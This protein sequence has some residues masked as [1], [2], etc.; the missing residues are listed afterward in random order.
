MNAI[1]QVA[2]TALR[3]RWASLT[4]REQQGLSWATLALA[5]LL[6]WFAALQPAW[7]TWQQ[8]PTQR[9]ALETQALH[10]Q[11][12]ASDA[13]ELKGQSPVSAEQSLQALKAATDRLGAKA[14]LSLLGERAT[15]TVT[16]ITPEQLQAWLSEVRSGARAR[17]VDL[18][19]RR[20]ANGLDG[21]VVLSLPASAG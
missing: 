1:T 21:M 8:V 7:R 11:R 19:L 20:N 4:P 10:M 5:V 12:L 18:Q 15:L 14:K 17:P 3:Q 16:G 13:R 2:T 9:Q 6:L